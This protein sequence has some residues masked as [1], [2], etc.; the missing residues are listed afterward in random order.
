MTKAPTRRAGRSLRQSFAVRSWTLWSVQPRWLVA[1]ILVVIAADLTALGVAA[2]VTVITR[3]DLAL[4]CL[5]LGCTVASLELTRKSGEQGGMIKDV[6]GVWEL[7][8]AIVLPPLYA[9]MIPII[10]IAM[11]QC[12]IRRA[13]VYRRAYSGAMLSLAYGAASVTFHGLSGLIPQ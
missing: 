5:L 1:F 2:T 7:P 11:L 9:L 13:P 3:S 10:R 12:R 8:T 6:H 4:F